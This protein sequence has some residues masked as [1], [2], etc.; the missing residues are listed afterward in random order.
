MGSRW[1][2]MVR[3]VLATASLLAG[4]ALPAAAGDV[5]AFMT[6]P[7]P[8][9]IWD[10]GYGAAL[11][12]T[13]F[14]AIGLE[15]EAARMP[16]D[17]ADGTMT[18][19]TASALLAPPVGALT[20]YGG[21]GFGLY[22]QTV[23]EEGETSTLRCFILGAKLRLGLLVVRGD[24]RSTRLSGDPLLPMDKRYSLGAGITF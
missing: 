19:F 9:D 6:F 24:Y 10:R 5:T 2:W 12:S 1:G 14:Q 16:L 8:G 17:S 20:F 13:W 15:A 11:T 3:V 21:V 23:G 22:R 7:S 18:S 4:G